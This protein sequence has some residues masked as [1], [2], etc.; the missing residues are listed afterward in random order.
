[1][2]KDAAS[3]ME[4]VY[5]RQDKESYYNA[6]VSTIIRIGRAEEF[7]VALS[8]LIQRLTVDHLHIVGDIYDLSLIHISGCFTFF[9][10]DY[11]Y[12]NA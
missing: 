4:D 6:I 1:M 11:R 8:E 2:K 3:W 10:S 9:I 7:I 12:Y 5:K